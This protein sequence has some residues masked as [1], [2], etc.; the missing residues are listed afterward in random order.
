MGARSGGRIDPFRLVGTTLDRRFRIDD[1]VAEG[2][3]GVVYRA[4]QITLDRPVALKVLKVPGDLSA[5]ERSQ[6]QRNFAAE[7]RTIA[8]LR[9]PSIVEVF[10]FGVSSER[11]GPPLLWMAL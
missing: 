3:Y 2:G 10:D 4:Y 6:F 11:D 1:E 7:A 8:R 5:E 9:H